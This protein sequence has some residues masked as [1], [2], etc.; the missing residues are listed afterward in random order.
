MTT[1]AMRQF[2]VSPVSVLA[3]GVAALIV[4]P[5]V[6]VI[7]LAL[8]A[9]LAVWNRLLATRIPELLSNT[10]ALA[11][12]AAVG[13]LL[14]GVAL[15][16]VVT[17]LDFAGRRV[18]EWALVLPLA[19]PSYV[20]AYIYTYLLGMGGPIEQLWQGLVGPEGQVFSPYSFAGATLVMTLGN[21]PFVYLLTRA[22]L[23][24]FNVSFEEVARV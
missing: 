6:Y 21:Y 10:I 11:L 1:M 22:A 2:S 18:W 9:D 3:I 20:L 15:A 23:L 14:L 5:L 12:S 8:S 24:N 7:Y 17:R 19:L 4:L 16:W 13:T